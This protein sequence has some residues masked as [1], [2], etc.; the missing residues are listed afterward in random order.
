M[1]TGLIHSEL[2]MLLDVGRSLVEDYNTASEG[3]S[4]FVTSVCCITSSCI[5]DV[6]CMKLPSLYPAHTPLQCFHSLP[7]CF[8][9]NRRFTHTSR[10]ITSNISHVILIEICA[11]ISLQICFSHS[12]SEYVTN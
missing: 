7:K 8:I 6:C 3:L 4:F 5:M 9:T 1:H 2:K 10:D 11:I 12:E